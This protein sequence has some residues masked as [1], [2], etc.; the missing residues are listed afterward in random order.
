MKTLSH[1]QADTEKLALKIAENLKVKDV[2]LLW[3]ALGAGKSVFARALIRAVMNDPHLEVPSPTFSLV[4]TYQSPRGSLYHYDLYR[5][6]NAEEI[7][8]LGWEDSLSDGINIIEWPERLSG[9]L[10]NHALNI[11]L[12]S[13]GDEMNIREIIIEDNRK[14]EKPHE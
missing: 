2:V 9:F 3:G 8:E 12:K 13:L 10:P 1:S 14:N 11:R 7:F 4:Q 5:I 6:E